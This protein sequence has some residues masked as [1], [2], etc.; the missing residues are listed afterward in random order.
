MGSN[1]KYL[2]R[3]NERFWEE[4]SSAPGLADDDLVNNTWETTEEMKSGP[5]EMVAFSGARSADELLAM[6]DQQV[7]K[8]IGGIMELVYPRYEK[9]VKKT[10]LVRWPKKKWTMASYYFPRVGDVMKW[11]PN[12]KKGIGGWL[13]FAGEHTCFAFPGYMEGALQ[14]G[15]RIARKIA[16]LT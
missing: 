7:K 9:S 2:M 14:S 8:R 3:F 5:F 16:G 13:H 1:T 4:Y 11:G 6:T 10:E 12:W 15:Y